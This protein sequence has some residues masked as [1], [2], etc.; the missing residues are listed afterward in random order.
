[1]HKPHAVMNVRR[2]GPGGAHTLLS[3][4]DGGGLT[5]KEQFRVWGLGFKGLGFRAILG[6]CWGYVGDILGLYWGNIRVILGLYWG[7][8]GVVIGGLRLKGL[9]AFI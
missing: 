1:M 9:P 3:D 6:L 4:L 7:Y 8:L 2:L 5:R